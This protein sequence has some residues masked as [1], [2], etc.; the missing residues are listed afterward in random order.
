MKQKE[1]VVQS[2]VVAWFR[3]SYPKYSRLLQASL[4][5]AYLSSMPIGNQKDPSV[6][7]A[8]RWRKLKDT[9]A[10]EGAADLFL[11]IPSGRYHGLFIEMKTPSG[12]QSK[13]QR[14]FQ[15]DVEAQGYM[16]ALCKGFDEAVHCIKKYI[17]G[18]DG[19]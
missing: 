13:E 17:S 7:R 4:N 10:C 12:K 15:A 6:C 5:G 3:Y 1:H 2:H 14:M 8:I 19:C 18:G 16:Y 11:A 9:G